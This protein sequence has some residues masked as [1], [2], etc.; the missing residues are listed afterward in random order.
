MQE[1]EER[2]GE[3]VSSSLLPDNS[4]VHSYR[5]WENRVLI[6]PFTPEGQTE[7]G[8]WV[9]KNP[10]WAKIWGWILAVPERTLEENPQLRPG[11]MVIYRRYAEEEVGFDK[12][13]EE[14]FIGE[15][16]PVCVIHID[17]LEAVFDP[18]LVPLRV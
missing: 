7:S 8:L 11:A 15:D 6:R 18:P 12:P 17:A 5:C 9:T 14:N 16:L 13:L 4:C 3:L 2:I 10:K 1:T